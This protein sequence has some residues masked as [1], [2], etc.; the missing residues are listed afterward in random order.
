MTVRCQTIIENLH[1]K[2]KKCVFLK[3]CSV[4]DRKF[5]VHIL[6]VLSL[7]VLEQSNMMVMTM[8]PMTRHHFHDISIPWSV[9]GVAVL[10]RLP[11]V[12]LDFF[13]LWKDRLLFIPHFYWC[14]LFPKKDK[15][16]SLTLTLRPGRWLLPGQ[17]Q[18]RRSAHW[19]RLHLWRK[20]KIIMWKCS[21][22]LVNPESL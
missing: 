20:E 19:Q 6:L 13:F 10:S 15:S 7:P 3:K 4:A 8:L 5:G 22:C 17:Q 1:L 16:N 9:R 21:S 2:Q 14:G 18:E 12:F 11:F